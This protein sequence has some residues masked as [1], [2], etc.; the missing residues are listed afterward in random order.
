[1]N[2]CILIC[3]LSLEKDYAISTET[4]LLAFTLAE[5]DTSWDFSLLLSPPPVVFLFG[6]SLSRE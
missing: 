5:N 1:M 2:A 3:I 4:M 6:I